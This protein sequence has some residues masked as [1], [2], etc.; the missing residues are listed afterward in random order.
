MVLKDLPYKLFYRVIDKIKKKYFTVAWG[1][2]P[3]IFVDGKANQVED[4]LRRNQHAEGMVQSY[5]YEG[6]EIGLRIPWGLDTEGRQREL[7]IRGR[8]VDDKFQLIAHLEL[9]RYEHKE[10]HINEVNFSWREGT[11]LLIS[12]ME[13]SPF[14]IIEVNT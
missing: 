7:H 1:T 12:I 9:S 3:N 6:Q 8:Y 11:Q 13:Q 10:E 4:W 5:Y 2:Y 14:G